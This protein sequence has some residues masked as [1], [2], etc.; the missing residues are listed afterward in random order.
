MQTSLFLHAIDALDIF[1]TFK[2][3]EEGDEK[4]LDIVREKFE[5]YF[6]PKRNLTYERHIFLQEVK[7]AGKR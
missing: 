3:E 4:K 2:F 1:N 5:Q 7:K 6:V